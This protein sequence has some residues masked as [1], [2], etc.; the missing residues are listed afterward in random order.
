MF[1]DFVSPITYCILGGGLFGFL[2][3]IILFIIEKYT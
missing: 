2:L 1:K 3:I